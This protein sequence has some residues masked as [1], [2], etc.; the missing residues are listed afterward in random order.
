MRKRNSLKVIAKVVKELDPYLIK[1]VK[2]SMRKASR[3]ASVPLPERMLR[4]ATR[5][6]LDWLDRT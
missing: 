5:E 6:F 3:P 2:I 1:T 4:A